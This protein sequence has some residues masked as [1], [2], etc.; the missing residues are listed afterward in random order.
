MPSTRSPAA[1]PSSPAPS[2]ASAW[3]RRRRCRRAARRSSSPT[4]TRTRDRRGRG[5]WA[6]ARCGLGADVTDRA[7]MDAVVAE[8]VE[9][10]GGLD[11]VVANAG[12]APTPGTARV[13]DD[14]VFERVIEVD[15]LGSGARC[16][17]ALPQITARGGHVVV[18]SSIYAFTNGLGNA[19]VRDGQGRR[20]AAR[21]ARCAPSCRRTARA[22]PPPTSAS[23]TRRW[24]TRR[25]TATRSATA[26]ERA[27]KPL[28]KRLPPSAAGEGIVR[29]DREARAPRSS[30]RAAGAALSVLRG[31]LNPFIDAAA[32]QAQR[33]PGLVRTLDA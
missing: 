7:R 9:R 14:G 24:C 2:A 4:S 30:C 27:P 25:S 18:V 21:A 23:S 6:A 10:F 22:R 12:I 5:S 13:M 33:R 1:S 20:R 31:I 17:P 19:P 8:V 28:H 11:V 26:D 32:D 15:L 3:P 29:G 16:A